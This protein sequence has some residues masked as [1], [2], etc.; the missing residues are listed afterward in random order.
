ML[1]VSGLGALRVLGPEHGLHVFEQPARKRAFERTA[2]RV[3]V[4]AQPVEPAPDG[5]PA[6]RRRALEAL[7]DAPAGSA[8]V[9]R[10]RRE[11]SALVR[12]GVRGWRSGRLE[13]VLD[14]DF[15]LIAGD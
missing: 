13:R 2:V 12:D 4:A 14:G 3:T 11:P 1:A 9:R 10:Y 6:R 7:G 8:I 15:D 5:Q